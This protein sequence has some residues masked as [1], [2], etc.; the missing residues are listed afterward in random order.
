MI[1]SEVRISCNNK[2]EEILMNM[3]ID[4][5]KEIINDFDKLKEMN[6]KDLKIQIGE[7]AKVIA[8]FKEK[9]A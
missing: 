4:E 2:E 8:L 7:I 1:Y 3:W 6:P 9:L 5:L